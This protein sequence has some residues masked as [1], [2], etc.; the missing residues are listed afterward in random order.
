MLMDKQTKK[1]DKQTNHFDRS[2]RKIG[3]GTTD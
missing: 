3:E 2:M 1:N